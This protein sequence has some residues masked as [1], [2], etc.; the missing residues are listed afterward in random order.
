MLHAQVSAEFQ[1]LEYRP[2]LS[3]ESSLASHNLFAVTKKKPLPPK[4]RGASAPIRAI[5]LPRAAAPP[6]H[7]VDPLS[8]YSNECPELIVASSTERSQSVKMFSDTS[9]ETLGDDTLLDE[10]LPPETLYYLEP[11]RK[12]LPQV[13]MP[14]G[15]EAPPPLPIDSYSLEGVSAYETSEP[16]DLQA[17]LPENSLDSL[18]RL[19]SKSLLSLDNFM[20]LES[21][22]ESLDEVSS[23]VKEKSVDVLADDGT[24]IHTMRPALVHDLRS[25]LQNIP[26]ESRARQ[27]LYAVDILR[28]SDELEAQPA[29]E[30]PSG[31]LTVDRLLHMTSE[32]TESDRVGRNETVTQDLSAS[33]EV[34]VPDERQSLY[35]QS[36]L[37]CRFHPGRRRSISYELS[38]LENA[39]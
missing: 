21:T 13:T 16:L 37:G 38:S 24:I 1:S 19:H 35:R 18:P 36:G 9:R 26:Y 23:V 33:L 15:V 14:E 29:N 7:R 12:F 28:H 3:P 2:T 8:A 27:L 6:I 17:I 22:L 32:L 4:F 11:P 20:T 39:V 34:P 5:H 31:V 25:R 10:S 30:P